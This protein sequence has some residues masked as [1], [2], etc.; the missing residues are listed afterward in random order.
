MRADDSYAGRVPRPRSSAFV[1]STVLLLVTTG[2]TAAA[3][4]VPSSVPADR[5]QTATDGQVETSTTALGTTTTPS[6]APASSPPWAVV[7]QDAAGLAVEERAFTSPSGRVVTLARFDAGSAVFDLHIGSTDPPTNLA[8]IPPDRGPA[9]APDEAPFLIGAFNGGFKMN[10]GQGGVEVQGQV[11]SPLLPG[12]ASFVIDTNGSAHIGI[13]GAGLPVV[14]EQVA[15]VRQNQAPLITGG[16]AS[17]NV[18]SP[19]AW[20]ATVN[21][22][23]V[24]AR[25]AVG[26]DALGNIIYGG[27]ASLLPADLSAALL[28]AG[29]VNAMQLDINPEWVQM[30]AA[31]AAGAPLVAQ[32]PGQN[33]PASQYLSGWTRDFFAVMALQ[34]VPRLRPR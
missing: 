20:G 32:V 25:S 34:F 19:A 3:S 12:K 31:A 5:P 15:S 16:V 22:S 1:A 26:E 14:G 8:T 29:A 18:G 2:S 27:G 33:R 11:V 24:V 17:P 23:M 28:S 10:A 4:R 9:I 6:T 13:W 30:D 21:R 7:S